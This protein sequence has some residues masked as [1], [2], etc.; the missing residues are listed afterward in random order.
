M[1][2]KLQKKTE[3][4]YICELCGFGYRSLETA[5]LCEEYCDIH[6]SYSPEIHKKAISKPTLRMIP[7]AA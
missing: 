3:I 2:D 5:E 1:V 6:G 4:M 7:L